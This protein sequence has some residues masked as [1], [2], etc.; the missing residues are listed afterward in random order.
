MQGIFAQAELVGL[1]EK[2]N[3]ILRNFPVYLLFFLEKKQTKQKTTFRSL[4][5]L[6]VQVTFYLLS[7]K[8]KSLKKCKFDNFMQCFVRKKAYEICP[9]N[10]EKHV[11]RK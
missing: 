4:S 9:K 2:A 1:C 6:F 3:R 10:Y 7:Y 11:C 5:L 8:K